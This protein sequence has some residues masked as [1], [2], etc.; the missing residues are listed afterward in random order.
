MNSG[1]NELGPG[2]D[3]YETP[4][5]YFDGL[6]TEFGFTMDGAARATPT[7]VLV[8]KD[9][10]PLEL[11]RPNAL[12]LKYSTKEAQ[13]PWGGE[14]VFCNPPYSAIE[15]ILQNAIYGMPRLA[16]FL[17]P[18]RTDNDWFPMLHKSRISCELRFLRKRIRFCLNG[19][20]ADSPRF[21]SLLA[22][23]R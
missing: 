22:I 19:H 6:D 13:L 23:I 20:P 3:E 15:E 18:V 1:M 10:V 7:T 5:W 16:V 21:S 17:L 9:R 8:G 4:K 12:C 2:T 14:R 11:S